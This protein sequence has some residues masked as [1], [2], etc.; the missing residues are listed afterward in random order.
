MPRLPD[1]HPIWDQHSGG[2]GH[3]AFPEWSDGDEAAARMLYRA[4]GAKAQVF[5]DLLMR[6][7][8]E[9]LTSEQLIDLAPDVFSAG[10]RS[11]SGALSSMS[12]PRE[13]SRRRFP[14]YWWKG[15]PTSYGM[16]AGVAVVFTRALH[17]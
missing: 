2:D 16:R 11:I 9:L 6:H 1:D 3:S 17:L 12:A 5:L 14:F 10:R 4:S 13:A 8:G 7:P 15:D